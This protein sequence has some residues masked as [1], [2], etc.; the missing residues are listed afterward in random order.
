MKRLP[1]ILC[2]ALGWAGMATAAEQCGV[3]HPESRV[4]YETSIH[5]RE[6]FECTSCHGGDPA[7][8]SPEAA[9]RGNFRA[10]GD[11]LRIP[12]ACAECHADMERMRP[13]NLP[14]DQYAV[15]LTSQHGQA[16]ARGE[17]RAAVCTDC[18]GSH[19]ILGPA[20]PASPV[21]HRH[22]VDTCGRCH[23]DQ[24]LM[25][26]FDLDPGV[27]DEYR[28]G[29]H[30]RALLEGGRGAAPDCT[31]CH[32]VHGAAPP[33]YGDIDKVC[34]ACHADTR[35]AFIAGRHH[36]AM[37][38]A[39]LP[40]CIACHDHHEVRGFGLEAI[41]TACEECHD[42]GSEQVLLGRQI[43]TVLTSAGEELD[44]A[45]QLAGKAQRSAVHVQ[46][47]LSRIEEARTYL[48]EA[49]PLVHSVELE[50]VEG[51]ARRARSI[52]EEVRHELYEKLDRR[53]AR[54]GLAVFWFYLL[55]TLAVLIVYKRRLA[56]KPE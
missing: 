25:R 45:E 2:A 23:G 12:A 50:P 43:F 11:R 41:E 3:C 8:R 31:S 17:R 38:A 33:G 56:A 47:H 46:D 9:H 18:H 20:D 16:I 37:R 35:S 5:A 1:V 30:G 7:S 21:N 22:L 39:G 26:A 15:Y 4:A 49:L 27:V 13:Y 54:I 14:V 53:P 42:E 29:V 44:A 10:L 48:T 28:A 32:G 36:D 34:G 52:G 55:M 40:E 24:G 51:L 19:G 6:G